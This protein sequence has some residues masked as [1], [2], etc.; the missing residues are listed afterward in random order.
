MK[1][2][3]FLLFLVIYI[4]SYV[5]LYGQTIVGIGTIPGFKIAKPLEN[6]YSIDTEGFARFNYLSGD[7]EDENRGFVYGLTDASMFVRKA[8]DTKWDWELGYLFRWQS[9]DVVRHRFIQGLTNKKVKGVWNFLQRVRTDLTISPQT[10]PI[11]RARYRYAADFPLFHIKENK[12]WRVKLSAEMINIFQ[13]SDYSIE[14]RFVTLFNHKRKNGDKVDF[15][16]DYRWADIFTRATAVHNF[17]III[18][19]EINLK[20]ITRNQ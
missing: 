11:I 3:H 6:G 8:R 1:I 16:L 9:D 7:L 2:T 5:F 18:N 17:W 4:V 14:M 19:Y 20:P 10:K 15:G 12:P 13:S